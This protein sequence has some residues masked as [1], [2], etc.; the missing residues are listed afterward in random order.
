[1]IQC[2]LQRGTK[3]QTSWIPEEFAKL[4][5]YIKVKEDGKWEDGWQV[6]SLGERKMASYVLEWSQDYKH[7]RE[8]SDI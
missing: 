5:K 2:Q 8:A 1:M 3:H 7:Q 4:G 6:K